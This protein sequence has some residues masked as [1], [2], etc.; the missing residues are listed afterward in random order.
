M[1]EKSALISWGCAKHEIV[2]LSTVD[3]EYVAV[4]EALKEAIFQEFYLETF[5][6]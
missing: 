4:T 5:L 2:S 3:A 1:N 6:I